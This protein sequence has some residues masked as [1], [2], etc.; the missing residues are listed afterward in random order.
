MYCTIKQRTSAGSYGIPNAFLKIC[1]K[2][3]AVPLWHIFN[4]FS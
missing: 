3:L 1:G 2:L 4:I